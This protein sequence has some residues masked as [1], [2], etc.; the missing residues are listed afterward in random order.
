[1]TV[2]CN[3]RTVAAALLL[4]ANL[5]GPA[6]AQPARPTQPAVPPAR[7][8]VEQPSWTD[9]AD[10]A[11]AAPIVLIADVRRVNRLGRRATPDVPPGEVRALIEG[12]LRTVLKAPGVLPA[13]AAWLWQGPADARG[14]PTVSRGE[15]VL[16]FAQPL[17]GGRD[18]ATQ[19]VA[20]F[21]R[22]G[23]Q[24]WTPEAEAIVRAILTE[25]LQPGLARL[26]VTGIQDA[27]WTEGDVPGQSESQFFLSTAEGRPVTL[28]VRRAPGEAPRV[29]A[30]TGDL[31]GAA[32]PVEPRTLTWRALACG[33]PTELP[34]HLAARAEL[35]ADYALARASLGA[36]WRRLAAALPRPSRSTG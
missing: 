12:D 26:A 16:L 3:P 9:W 17:S 30:A 6:A 2:R 25:A 14:R 34:A 23:Q 28:L 8:A 27:F 15:R 31:V 13:G 20:L 33:L 11:L 4:A 19:P 18:P 32:A 35:R 21:A 10:L 7:P 1:V 36:C 24:A 22:H 29:L 5:T